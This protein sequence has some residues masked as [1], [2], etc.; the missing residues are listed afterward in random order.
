MAA[1]KTPEICFIPASMSRMYLKEGWIE[2]A[3]QLGLG[4]F[5][6][7]P[8]KSRKGDA[9]E[10]ETAFFLTRS[11]IENIGQM[12]PYIDSASLEVLRRLRILPPEA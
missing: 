7:P 4:L 9:V 1:T 11:G 10:I 5:A 8:P 12:Q 6:G 3:P 2:A